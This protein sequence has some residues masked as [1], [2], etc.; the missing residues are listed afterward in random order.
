MEIFDRAIEPLSRA[1]A[2]S[3][4][5]PCYIHERAKAY[6]LVGEFKKAVEDYSRVIELQPK[7][8]HAFFG[9]GFA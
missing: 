1:I 3:K 5:E 6:L 8:P 2:L 7:N 9:R 4:Y